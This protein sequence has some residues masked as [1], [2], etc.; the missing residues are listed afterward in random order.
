MRISRSPLPVLVTCLGCLAGLDAQGPAFVFPSGLT[1]RSDGQ[2]I[3]ADRG[4]HYVF[5]IDPKTGATRVI[6]GT[7]TPGFSGDGGAPTAAQFQNPEWVEYDRLGNLV[8]ADRGNHRVR[9][10]DARTNVVTTIAGTGEN[11]S[12]GDGGPA[13]AASMTNPFGVTHDRD[14]HLYIFDTEVHV[15][16]RVDAKTGRIDTV[17]GDRQQGFSGDGGPAIAARLYRPHNG[18]FDAAGRLVFGDSF[19]QRIRRWDPSTGVITTIAGIGEAGTSPDGTPARLARFRYFG[20]M[21]WVGGD[22]VFTSLDHR[23][24]TIEGKSG[25]LRLIAGTGERGFS[26]DGGPARSAQLDTPYGLAVTAEGDLIVADAANRRVRRIDMR[27]G[28]IR[29]VAGDGR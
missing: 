1:I 22:L 24:L 4:A 6:V 28:I 20:A 21:V 10:I 27:T 3:M 16:R 14:G 2:I 15:I 26:G 9:K 29:T 8:V 11:A 5:A 7:G 13:T 18:V 23:I 17:V 19:N 25:A 12:N